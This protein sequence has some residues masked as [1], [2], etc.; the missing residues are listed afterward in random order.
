MNKL[1]SVS[2]MAIRSIEEG[3][4]ITSFTPCCG[5]DENQASICEQRDICAYQSVCM[6][7]E[8]LFNFLF[9][10]R[11]DQL[12]A[13]TTFMSGRRSRWKRAW[14][15]PFWKTVYLLCKI[16]LGRKRQ[17]SVSVAVHTL[18]LILCLN[19]CTLYCRICHFMDAST[20]MCLGTQVSNVLYFGR[21][22][23]MEYYKMNIN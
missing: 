16:V 2:A 8:L 5:P 13:Y 10:V 14:V 20:E 6:E 19:V 11:R 12:S 18:L 17:F 9:E 4:S 3:G 1:Q 15:Y 22:F 21:V 23:H 7:G